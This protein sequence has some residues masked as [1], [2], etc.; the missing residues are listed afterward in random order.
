M[1]SL[2]NFD[3]TDREYSLA[4]TYDPA[5]FWGSKVKVPAGLSKLLAKASTSTLGRRSPSFSFITAQRYAS[6]VYAVIM[7]LYVRLSVR[8]SVC[9]CLSQV[10]VLQRWLSLGSHEQRHTIAGDSFLL[11][12]ISAKF[13]R[14]HP[15][16]GCKKRWSR[17]K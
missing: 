7:C 16:R 12:K 9:L 11:P 5:R 4:P 8:P 17:F 15:Q 10:G 1:N 14:N 6:A 13:Q 3:K 2:N